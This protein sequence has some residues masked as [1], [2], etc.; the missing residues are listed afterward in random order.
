[1]TAKLEFTPSSESSAHL[2]AAC[3]SFCAHCGL[4]VPPAERAAPGEV[5]FCC[6]GCRTAYAIINQAGLGT[7][8]TQ[9]EKAAPAA[10]GVRTSARSYAEFDHPEFR[11]RH[12]RSA[13]DGAHL[14]LFLTGIHCTACIWLVE[15]LSRV[16]EGVH[17][18]RFELGRSALEIVFD[19]ERVTPSAIARG[20]A[21][22]G[23]PPH[24]SA[25]RQQQAERGREK[26][27]VTRLGI[28][29]AL[30]GNVMLM[31]LALYCGAAKDAEYAA[32]FRW[33]SLVL[34]I[35]SVFYC[36]G[37]F[38]RG[39]LAALRTRTPHMDLPVSIGILAGFARSAWNTLTARGE[40]YFDSISVLIFLLLVGRWLQQRHHRGATRALELIAALAPASARTIDGETTR[41]V[42]IAGLAP[43]ALILVL[44]N[45]RIPADGV[46]LEGE[47]SVDT[48]WLTGESLPEEVRPGS[49]VYAGT[50]NTAASLKIRVETAGSETRLSRLMQSVEQAQ[51]RRAPIV[52]LADRV[53]GYFVLVALALSAITF[54]LW[55]WLDPSQ[56]LDHAVALLVVTCPCALGMATPLAVNAAL[57]RAA[58]AGIFFKGGE[59]LEALARPGTIAFDKTGTLT[60]GKLALTAYLGDDRAKP[61]LRA[62]EKA[63]AHPIARAL[64]AAFGDTAELA[65]EHSEERPGAGVIARVAGREVRVGSADLVSP[66]RPLGE[67]WRGELAR[68]AEQGRPTVLV[69]L[70][71]EVVA[72][73]AF[74][75]PL[76]ADASASI[77]R[78]REFGYRPAVLSGD[79]PEVV[80]NVAKTLG[81]MSDARGAMSPEQKLD[82]V[83][84]ARTAGPVV[85]VGD[86]VNDAAAMAAADVAIAVHGGA[87]ASLV[88][89]DAFTTLPGVGKV[90]EAVEGARR[91]LSVIRR[92][93]VFS[94]AYNVVGV[95]LCM[96]GKISP[97]LAAVL[98]PLSSLTVVATAL[99][100]RTFTPKDSRGV[101]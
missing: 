77:E 49:R 58:R 38:L 4:P 9:R 89:A 13:A 32:L 67:P 80:A 34:A 72:L 15:R 31:A 97:L 40:V 91:T 52:R 86:G 92:G 29:F 26:A 63:S 16:V 70:D 19:P 68:H 99:R 60:E 25:E 75:D 1:M 44:E 27:L 33:G 79:R 17:S 14:E 53:A 28:A 69:A 7:Y 12:V 48:S 76:R 45:E 23:Y 88:A 66:G 71:G 10:E 82:W 42:P 85:M 11:A 56:A 65:V 83:N 98:M 62:A 24:P 2:V 59:F 47:S 90:L 8:Y 21:G 50:Q 93:I 36:G 35:P 51:S 74:S 37:V 73:A 100:S 46:V 96:A 61:F 64:V 5:S 94:L 20:L 101:P 81:K 41:E 39:A 84:R 30:A 6:A 22:L 18:A 43:N 3:G 57:G 87:E 95:G 54:A 55:W 78:L